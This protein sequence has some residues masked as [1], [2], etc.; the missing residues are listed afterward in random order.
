MTDLAP[1]FVDTDYSD[2][3]TYM[4][5]GQGPL[6]L[7]VREIRPHQAK[8]VADV[9]SA[10]EAGADVVFL[11]APTG[12]GKT[13][14]G[15]LVRRVMEARALYVCSDKSLQHQFVR[16]FD[17]SKML[18]GR[19]NYTTELG[20]R[21]KSADDCTAVT[22]GDACSW[23]ESKASC[24]Y[25]LA[26]IDALASDLAVL[27]TNYLLS[28]A[29]YTGSFTG[30]PLIIIDEADA[31]ENTLLGFVEYKVPQWVVRRCNLEIPRKGVHKSTLIRWLLDA[32]NV[33]ADDVRRAHG[34]VE[35]KLLRSMRSFVDETR[36]VADQ[37]QRD[38]DA[39]A[40]SEDGG[41]WLRVYDD[42]DD[43]LQLKPVLVAPFGTKNLWRHG[44]QFLLM[45]A[46]IISADE[47]ADTLGLPLDYATVSVPMTFPVENRPIILAPIADMTWKAGEDE[48]TK[49]AYA[50]QQVCDKHEGDRV[51]IH[52][53]SGDRAQ[54]LIAA[55]HELGGLGGRKIVSYRS[56][57]ERDMA[58]QRYLDK[59]GSVLFAQSMQRGIDLPGDACR[60]QVIAKA[61]FLS[62]GDKRVSARLHLPGGQAWYQVQAIRDIVQMTGRG[63]RSHDD[64]AT[65]YIFDS[66]F[67]RNLWKPQ[68]RAL[69]PG[70]WRDAVDR[71]RDVREFIY[72]G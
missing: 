44:K 20:P 18:K 60:V 66:Q 32:A 15:E 25:E 49:M 56:G 13:L 27:N 35:P 57:R 26:K 11:D 1:S 42:G 40:D 38:I 29:N 28:A 39:G 22:P 51:L 21:D 71:T 41:K 17:Y 62:L 23:C 64:Y 70:W 61:P 6:P 72:K 68:T 2:L 5:H 10:F 45:S 58:L 54:R 65:T 12:T 50:I 55:V 8:A 69:F 37:L 9:V 24:P 47:M 53:V 4:A 36:T 43:T 7:W 48:Y 14:I 19:S 63:V 33:V 59:P 52:T 46:T 30:R 34:L 67:S 31:L 16:D 3:S